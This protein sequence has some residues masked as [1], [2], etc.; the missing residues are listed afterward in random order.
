MPSYCNAKDV[1]PAELFAAL[2]KYAAGMQLYVPCPD[3]TRAAWGTRNGT[4]QGLE[5]RNH[6]IRRLYAEGVDLDEISRRFYLSRETVRK[7]VRGVRRK[8]DMIS[9]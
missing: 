6:Q 2:Q 4:R 5:Q 8:Q 1:L 9:R 3:E 7:I